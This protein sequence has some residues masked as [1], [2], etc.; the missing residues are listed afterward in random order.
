MS[1][2]T[3][4]MYSSTSTITLLR[5][6]V[7]VLKKYS[8]SSTSTSTRV[9]LIHLCYTYMYLLLNNINKFIVTALMICRFDCYI[10]CFYNIALK[11]VTQ[12]QCANKSID[13]VTIT[14]KFVLYE[15]KLEQEQYI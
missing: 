7:R 9:R 2:I 8:Y 4:V 6:R 3:S 13:S 12:L 14:T 15:T 5:T 11:N 10:S 1:T